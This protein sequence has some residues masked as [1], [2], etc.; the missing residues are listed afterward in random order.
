MSVSG[1]APDRGM[2]R[3]HEI[4]RA[5]QDEEMQLLTEAQAAVRRR[6]VPEFAG[7]DLRLSR[8]RSKGTRRMAGALRAQLEADYERASGELLS[9]RRDAPEW[10]GPAC[11][12]T[13]WTASADG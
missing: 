12:A 3:F 2:A 11:S 9:G 4:W 1:D 5:T 6:I 7:V 10:R 13:R 8:V